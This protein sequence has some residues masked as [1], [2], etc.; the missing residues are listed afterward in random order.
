[1]RRQTR[2]RAPG[3]SVRLHRPTGPK[4]ERARPYASDVE[5]GNVA[6]VDGAW[7]GEWLEEH[8]AFS[9]ECAH[10]DQVDAGSGLRHALYRASGWSDVMAEQTQAS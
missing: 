4:V 10:D 1:M 5:A 9:P 6:L 2:E 3:C 8:D 7:V